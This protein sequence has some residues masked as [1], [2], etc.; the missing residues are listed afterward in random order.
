MS[1]DVSVED[2]LRTGKW[3]IKLPMFLILITVIIVKSIFFDIIFGE[4]IDDFLVIFI[5]LLLCWLYWSFAIPIWKIW[6]YKNVR[7]IHELKLKA[8]K[9]NFIFRE[10]GF[11]EKTEI[12][13]AEQKETLKQL[14][15]KILV[16][17]VYRDDISVAKESK[18]YFS[19]I[20][21]SFTLIFLCAILTGFIYII[22]NGDLLKNMDSGL[23]S[24]ILLMGFLIYSGYGD[25]KNILNSNPQIILS[26]KGIQI[27]N[28]QMISWKDINNEFVYGK[29]RRRNYKKV[30]VFNDQEIIINDYNISIKELENLLH[31]Y[32]VRYERNKST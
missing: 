8:K 5:G 1:E 13:N 22:I 10:G 15:K 31:V 11:F 3:F 7:N 30:L 19:K 26:D 21:L 14:E 18:I 17:D 16:E 23:F 2:A 25:L 32:R 6:A 4:R 29:W 24:G 12:K 9:N 20:K 28:N 27:K